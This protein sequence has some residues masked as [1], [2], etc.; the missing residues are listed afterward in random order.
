MQC[1]EY[2]KLSIYFISNISNEV[3][4]LKDVINYNIFFCRT[5][6]K[7]LKAELLNNEECVID[8]VSLHSFQEIV[9][10]TLN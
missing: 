2:K 6:K 4:N 10:L 1:P 7:T 3:H 8:Q 9:N 5:N